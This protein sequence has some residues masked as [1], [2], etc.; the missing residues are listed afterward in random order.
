[1]SI[2]SLDMDK[3]SVSGFITTTLQ[4]YRHRISH[5][6]LQL[7]SVSVVS[8]HLNYQILLQLSWGSKRILDGHCSLKSH[9]SNYKLNEMTVRKLHG[10]CFQ[11]DQL[12]RNWVLCGEHPHSHSSPRLKANLNYYD[13]YTEL[14]VPLPGSITDDPLL[15]KWGRSP[16]PYRC[17]CTKCEL[18]IPSRPIQLDGLAEEGHAL[19]QAFIQSHYGY[20]DYRWI[21]IL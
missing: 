5:F 13:Y 1:M 3:R 19:I 20:A 9:H 2:Y 17:S 15:W 11:E 7:H 14:K 10:Q 4:W 18:W 21:T 6:A 8:Y 12:H 16:W